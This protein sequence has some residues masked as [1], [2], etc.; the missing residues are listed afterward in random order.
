MVTA[1]V[2]GATQSTTAPT[3]RGPGRP[4]QGPLIIG[5]GGIEECLFVAEG[6]MKGPPPVSP[7]PGVALLAPYRYRLC[8]T[9][10]LPRSA[11]WTKTFLGQNIACRGGVVASIS[12]FALRDVAA[13]Y[14]MHAIS[15]PLET[16]TFSRLC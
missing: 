8:P 16:L 6:R 13:L 1:F 10:R 15:D 3:M 9:I 5:V 11:P 7:T 14:S 12:S 2:L 4:F